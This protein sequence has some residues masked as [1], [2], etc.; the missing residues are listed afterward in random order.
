LQD[1]TASQAAL[2]AEIAKQYPDLRLG[3]G[4]DWDQGDHKWLLLGISLTLP[5]LNRNE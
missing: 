1:Y 3:P 5:I 2:Q 4:Y